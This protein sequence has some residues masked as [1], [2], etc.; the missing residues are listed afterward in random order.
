[1]TEQ[2]PGACDFMQLVACLRY[3]QGR[4]KGKPREGGGSLGKRESSVKV[5]QMESASYSLNSL[6]WIEDHSVGV[7]N[8]DGNCS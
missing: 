5:A 1:M 7:I 8:R 3:S 6:R 4:K 2:I